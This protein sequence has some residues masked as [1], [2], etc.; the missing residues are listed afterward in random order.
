MHDGTIGSLS[1]TSVVAEPQYTA[2]V[3]SSRMR[4]GPP[5]LR[6]I[7]FFEQLPLAAGIFVVVAA[8][9]TLAQWQAGLDPGTRFFPGGTFMLP[10]TCAALLLGG[11]SLALMAHPTD[12]RSL[13]LAAAALAVLLLA[14]ALLEAASWAAGRN[15]GLDLLLYPS[16][17][18]HA[19]WMPPG[20][21]ALN[22]VAALLFAGAG[23]LGLHADDRDGRN[24]AQWFALATTV[25]A[26]LALVGYAFGV[27][28]LYAL[29]A[30][31][32][33]ALPTAITLFVL[34]IGLMFARRT[35]G[36]AGLMVDPGAAGSVSRRLIP[37]AILVPFLIGW[38]RL[39]A[40]RSGLLDE[41]LGVSLY[42]LATVAIFVWLVWWAAQMARAGDHTRQDL[43]ER[44]RAARAAAEEANAAKSNFLAVM[45]HELRT[46][47]SAI[48]GYEELLADGITGPVNDAQRHQLGRV[49]ASAQHLLHLIDQILT[50]SRID[51][52]REVV[53]H[54]DVDANEMAQDAAGL[55][56]PLAQEKG[57]TVSVVPL[58]YALPMRTDGGKVRQILV[59]LLSNAVKFTASGNIAMSVLHDGNIVR[60][61]VRDTGIGIAPEH[62]DQIFEPFWQVEQPST[63]RVGGTGLGL[64]VT[65]RLAS[66]LGGTVTVE[67]AP[68][69][70][71]TF[72]ITLPLEA[73][74]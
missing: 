3:Y 41:T 20:R 19:P 51:A 68:G 26:F 32:G 54:E 47:L 74:A 44:E 71:S 22:T 12:R 70:G 48:I 17:V 53:R 16:A 52:G 15:L 34:G 13:Q 69:E 50:Y 21:M 49:K 46:P 6:V 4:T 11:G 8:V 31:S 57:L 60:Y 72:T 65:R 18:R 27:T 35:A 9:G 56:E 62:L 58:D 25:I 5:H 7:R 45:S 37:A 55:I 40:E 29:G 63:R 2:Q 10:V 30:Y 73:N 39:S 59:N 33:M 43:L 61:V 64:T 38:G 66:L 42:V 23:L 67:S 28:R 14:I 24:S 36:L 1:T